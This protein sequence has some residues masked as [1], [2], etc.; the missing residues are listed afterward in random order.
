[1]R[2]YGSLKHFI[3]CMTYGMAGTVYPHVE[4]IIQDEIRLA[5]GKL[6]YIGL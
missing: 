2:E 5:G 6:P 3:P 4:P 1:M